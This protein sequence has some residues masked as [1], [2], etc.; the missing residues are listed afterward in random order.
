MGTS[1][2]LCLIRP[3]LVFKYHLKIEAIQKDHHE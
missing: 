2:C 3:D 1:G